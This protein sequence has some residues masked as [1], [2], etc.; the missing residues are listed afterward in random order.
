MNHNWVSKL[1]LEL[2]RGELH[3]RALVKLIRIP[4]ATVQRKLIQLEKE[5]VLDAKIE[6]RNKVYF[7]KKGFSA[8]KYIFNAENDKFLELIDRYPF[9]EPI[10]EDV[11]K[12]CSG[13]MIILFGSYAKFTSTS[14]S[15]IDLYVET[16][17]RKMKADLENIH[18]KLNVKMGLF[19][20]NDLLIREIIKNHVV[21]RG[22]E[23]FYEKIKFF[24]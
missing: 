12:K 4:Q 6:G 5:N 21:I 19:N 8:K 18:S 23:E 3:G 9:L 7:I 1:I 14:K 10:I 24:E 13:E 11:L 2:V 15:D 22:E 17:N 16:N 20:P